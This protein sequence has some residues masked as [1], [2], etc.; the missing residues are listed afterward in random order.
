L[1]DI[2]LSTNNLNRSSQ[3]IDIAMAGFRKAHMR[4]FVYSSCHLY[5]NKM[6]ALRNPAYM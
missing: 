4:A 3:N 5:S 6:C 1:P 2:F